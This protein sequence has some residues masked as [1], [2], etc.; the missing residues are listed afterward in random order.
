MGYAG[1]TSVAQSDAGWILSNLYWQ[2]A[3]DG[4]A[5]SFVAGIVDPTDYVDVFSLGTPGRIFNNISFSTNPTIP[6]PN[7]GLGAAVRVRFGGNCFGF[8][9]ISDANGMQIDPAAAVDNLFDTGETFKHAAVGWLGSWDTRFDDNIQLTAWQIDDRVAAGTDGGWGAAFSAN[10]KFDSGLA[11]FFKAGYADGGGAL[12]DR[13]VSLGTGYDMFAGRDL[14]AV[15]LNWGRAPKSATLTDPQDQFTAELFYRYQLFSNL[16]ITP[17]LQ[18]I[19]NQAFDPTQGAI[20]V[21]SLR[22]RLTF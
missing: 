19:G 13:S 7:Q 11:P 8:A 5:V 2:Q 12:V 10:K 21:V 1:L 16:Q 3:F 9:G 18:L 22:A 4:N 20:A 14:V 15:G 17:S 6:A